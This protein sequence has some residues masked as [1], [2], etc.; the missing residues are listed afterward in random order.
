MLKLS[1]KLLEPPEDL[2]NSK[3]LEI[4]YDRSRAAELGEWAYENCKDYYAPLLAKQLDRSSLKKAVA[5][6]KVPAFCGYGRAGKDLAAEYL[7]SQYAVSAGISTSL[8]SLPLILRAVVAHGVMTSENLVYSS[9]HE[10]RMFWFD[11][12]NQFRAHDP[13]MIV[14]MAL[15]TSDIVVGIRSGFELHACVQAGL[16]QPT[17]WVDNPRVP[18]DPTVE[19]SAED[20]LV[21]VSNSGARE[22]YYRKLDEL[23]GTWFGFTKRTAV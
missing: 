17:V 11:F 2:P 15:A 23:A 21:T 19:F 20:C 9:R 7:V 16:V 14:R 13:T 22:S 1:T 10:N 18:V 8:V 6:I 5:G 3:R 12:L 4:P